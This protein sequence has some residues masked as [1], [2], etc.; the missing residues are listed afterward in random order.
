MTA[1]MANQGMAYDPSILFYVIAVTSLGHRRGIY[2]VA[3]ESRLLR[4]V[5]ATVYLC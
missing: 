1:G 4:R 2:D 5:L 3:W